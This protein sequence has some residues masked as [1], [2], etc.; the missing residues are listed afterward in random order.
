M[1]SE[2]IILG[3]AASYL[4]AHFLLAQSNLS[5]SLRSAL[6]TVENEELTKRMAAVLP[7]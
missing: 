5:P 7:A 2:S 4:L 1:K 6:Q 3:L